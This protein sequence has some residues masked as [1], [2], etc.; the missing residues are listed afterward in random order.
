[1]GRNRGDDRVWEFLGG[2]KAVAKPQGQSTDM[3]MGT[4]SATREGVR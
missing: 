1:M 2:V 3:G 4:S